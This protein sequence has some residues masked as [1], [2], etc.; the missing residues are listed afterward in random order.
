[1]KLYQKART[2]KTKWI[3]LYTEGRFLCSKWGLMDS[4]KI[5]ETRKECQAMNIG[6]VN[7]TTPEQQAIVEMEAKIKKKKENGYVE[8]L[9]TIESIVS[10][11]IDLDNIPKAFCP[12]KPAKDAPT[13]ILKSPD[14]FGQI[15]RN[16]HCVILSKTKNKKYIYSRGMED[17]TNHLDLIPVIQEMLD[18]MEEGSLLITEFCFVDKETG[19]DSPRKSGKV[20]RKQDRDEALES[21]NSLLDLGHF[22]V[23]PLDLMFAGYKFIGNTDYLTNR[24][25]EMKKHNLPNILEIIPNWKEYYE[26]HRSLDKRKA[27]DIEGLVLRNRGEKSYIRFTLNGKADKC[28]AWKL[29]YVYEDDFIVV[30]AEKG[31]AGKQAGLYA[32]Y[33]LAQYDSNGNLVEYGKCGPGKLNHD[34]LAELTKEI[35]DGNLQ[36][37]FVI[38]V[39]FQSRQEDSGCCEFPQFI[40][41]R[42][43][44]KPEGCI[45]DLE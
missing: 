18:A 28:G 15:K 32:K 8:T 16:G 43:D 6:K 20:A 36:F 40:R 17:K 41:V 11:E 26:Q 3:E 4:D 1:M 35:D 22:E 27:G 14:T 9:E 31:K 13:A 25:E 34:R 10:E 23:V 30:R 12:S 24:Y 39:E 29:K 5:Q 38:E 37:P 2:G 42:Y 19:K 21:Y 44:K 33:F 7:E 45:F